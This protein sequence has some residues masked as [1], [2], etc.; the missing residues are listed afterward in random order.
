MKYLFQIV[1]IVTLVLC[2]SISCS[3]ERNSSNAVIK[4]ETT[5]SYHE[6]NKDVAS[7]DKMEEISEDDETKREVHKGLDYD[8]EEGGKKSQSWDESAIKRSSEM[9]EIEPEIQRFEIE[10]TGEETYPDA[11]NAPPE[12]IA[13]PIPAP[14]GEMVEDEELSIEKTRSFGVGGSGGR[15]KT[16]APMLDESAS[17]TE[18]P[19][20]SEEPATMLDIE[21]KTAP[22]KQFRIR[23]RFPDIAFYHPGLV[24]D[25]HG[26][27]GFAFE[28]QDAITEYSINV[29]AASDRGEWGYGTASFRTFQSFFIEFNPPSKLHTNDTIKA[30]AAIF[31]YTGYSVTVNVSSKTNSD[32]LSVTSGNGMVT[33]PSGKVVEYPLTIKALNDGEASVTITA[34]A[35]D[36]RD[37]IRRQIVIHP[38]LPEKRISRDGL[39]KAGGDEISLEIPPDAKVMQD[40]FRLRIF[41]DPTYGALTDLRNLENEPHASL[42]RALS[43]WIMTSFA[44]DSLDENALLTDELKEELAASIDS[45]W[46][47]LLAFRNEDGFSIFPNANHNKI[48]DL[49]VLESMR[50]VNKKYIYDENIMRQLEMNASLIFESPNESIGDRLHAACLIAES[51]K[52]DPNVKNNIEEFIESSTVKFSSD[53]LIICLSLRCAVAI[54]QELD[55]N[56]LEKIANVPMQNVQRMNVPLSNISSIHDNDSIFNLINLFIA[57]KGT[58]KPIDKKHMSEISKVNVKIDNAAFASDIS[59]LEKAIAIMIISKFKSFEPQ[60]IESVKVNDKDISFDDY[61]LWSEIPITL[62]PGLNTINVNTKL[63]NVRYQISGRYFQKQSGSDSDNLKYSFPNKLNTDRTFNATFAVYAPKRVIKKESI[64]RLPL[65]CGVKPIDSAYVLAQRLG[66]EYAEITSDE[67]ILYY[68]QAAPDIHEERFIPMKAKFNGEFYLAPP[69]VEDIRGAVDIPTNSG[70][71]ISWL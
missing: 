65:P 15:I 49:I 53:P 7:L 62:K 11:E 41:N 35:G 54:G 71:Q 59:P 57:I 63:K 6:M 36:I 33:V 23:S 22:I 58:N 45:A 39:L 68:S 46:L 60:K 13:P 12:D 21:E 55:L 34:S 44:Y 48:A 30:S 1:V 52:I 14:S 66:A 20:A 5:G 61:S 50:K 27:T 70:S 8:E 40:D 2:F 29:H 51:D 24:T 17:E 19:S 47:R 16:K 43:I 56:K 26:E 28:A 32:I 67:I 10:E 38:D 64:I 69:T 3:S 37:S 4:Q 25:I 9:N 42:T 31:N 18:L